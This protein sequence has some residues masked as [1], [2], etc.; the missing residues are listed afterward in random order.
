MQE[1][2]DDGD[3]IVVGR[4]REDGLEG[5]GDVARKPFV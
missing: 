3:G 5:P 1:A 4:L 2:F